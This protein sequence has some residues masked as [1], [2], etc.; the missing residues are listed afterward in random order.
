[1]KKNGCKIKIKFL[2]DC[3]CDHFE[4]HKFFEMCRFSSL[5]ECTNRKAQRE[6]MKTKTRWT[7]KPATKEGFYKLN[8]TTGD[9]HIG[10]PVD[11]EMQD[12]KT[13]EYRF[14]EWETLV[15]MGYKRSVKPIEED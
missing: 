11:L 5:D 7:K 14:I 8:D 12:W 15:R 4:K 1:M 9:T 6:A 10:W 3:P 2:C 13:D